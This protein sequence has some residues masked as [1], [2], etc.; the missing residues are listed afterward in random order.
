MKEVQMLSG[1]NNSPNENENE[2]ESELDE[3]Y[4]DKYIDQQLNATVL[5]DFKQALYDVRYVAPI[6][7]LLGILVA[8]H[9]TIAPFRTRIV[10]DNG[11]QRV[12]DLVSVS[13]NSGRPS[14]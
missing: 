9:L 10:D 8:Y 13:F 11:L 4:D 3:V 1:K 5:D 6:L 2:T 7:A 12:N 14:C